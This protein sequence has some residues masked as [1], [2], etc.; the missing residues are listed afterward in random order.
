MLVIIAAGVELTQQSKKHIPQITRPIPR[1]LFD[2]LSF[3]RVPS[4]TNNKDLIHLNVFKKIK[5]IDYR[6]RFPIRCFFCKR[7][8][9]VD[10]PISEKYEV[11]S[12]LI[13]SCDFLHIKN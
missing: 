10:A 6:Q 2:V 4:L 9:S 8:M 13:F 11:E 3:M 12:S 7:K 1:F 5:F